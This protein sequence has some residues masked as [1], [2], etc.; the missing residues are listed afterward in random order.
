MKKIYGWLTGTMARRP[1]VFTIV[2]GIACYTIAMA[3]MVIFFRADF[4]TG[5][6]GLIGAT[7]LI[8]FFHW[9]IAFHVRS[10]LIS[11]VIA[12]IPAI[13]LVY[14]VLMAMTQLGIRQVCVEDNVTGVIGECR[15]VMD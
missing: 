11:Q 10:S 15:F 1:L 5:D 4:F 9:F 14:L 8:V 6:I 2:S 13:C 12:V 7:A 3:W